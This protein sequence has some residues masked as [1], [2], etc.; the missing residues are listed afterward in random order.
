MTLAE[1]LADGEELCAAIV[2]VEQDRA[3]DIL[4]GA[5][6]VGYAL[7]HLPRLL[8]IAKAAVEMRSFIAHDTSDMA[9]TTPSG[10]CRSV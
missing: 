9:Q 5:A 2:D 3:P 1:I 10:L 6:L 8:K 4:V 7:V